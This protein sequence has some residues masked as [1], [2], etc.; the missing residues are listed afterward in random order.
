MAFAWLVTIPA[1][2]TMAAGLYLAVDEIGDGL[3]GPLLVSSVGLLAAVGLFWQV[4]RSNAVHRAGR[5][6]FAAI[7]DW[8]AL[9]KVVLYSFAGAAV[10]TFLFTTG[11]VLVEA[12]QGRRVASLSRTTGVAAFAGCLA[13]VVLGVYV[14][15][16]TK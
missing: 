3:L 15:L 5:L 13:L 12:N 9:G 8:A 11:V 1:A 6:M 14:M 4:Q 16:T 2:A 7:V 10:L